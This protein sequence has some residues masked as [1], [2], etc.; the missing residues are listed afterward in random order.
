MKTDQNKV[1]IYMICCH[2]TPK[3]E[4]TWII[5]STIKHTRLKDQGKIKRDMLYATND[6]QAYKERSCIT[7][8]PDKE[9][10]PESSRRDLRRHHIQRTRCF[11]LLNQPKCKESQKKREKRCHL[12]D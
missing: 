6:V 1:P 10:V 8:V 4:N 12:Y 5:I 3:E 11:I 9:K 2:K 7:S